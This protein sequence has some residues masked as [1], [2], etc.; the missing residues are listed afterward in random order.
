MGV[1]GTLN[2]QPPGTVTAVANPDY[3]TQRGTLT[4]TLDFIIPPEWMCGDL[5][6]VAR[7]QA[8]RWND[9]LTTT[10]VVQL[11]QTLRLAGVMISYNSPAAVVARMRQ[12][13]RS[14]RRR[15]Q[16]SRRCRGRR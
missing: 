10:V 15:W 5:G 9:T 4:E 7:V 13:S 12:I 6:L 8:G 14:P 3:A 16:T 11:R 1:A 2:P